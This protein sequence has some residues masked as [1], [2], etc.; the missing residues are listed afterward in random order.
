[1]K[2][3]GGT[4]HLLDLRDP[5]T[6]QGRL[7]LGCAAGACHAGGAV[8]V[9]WRPGAEHELL[10]CGLDK[11]LKLWDARSPR[12]PLRAFEG[13]V[14]CGA[15]AAP[16]GIIRPRWLT[17][18]FDC[19]GS[20]GGSGGP[21]LTIAVQGWGSTKLTLFEAE[22]GAVLSRGELGEAVTAMAQVA[23]GPCLA[24]AHEEG[25]IKL[26]VPSEP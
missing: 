14:P 24:V 13:H 3:E 8:S 5:R 12:A 19:G 15:R 16:K 6:A 11:A 4:V 23:A 25:D 1:M 10:S 20:G 7:A 18:G 21:A 2:G 26:L 17:R 9:E 22:T